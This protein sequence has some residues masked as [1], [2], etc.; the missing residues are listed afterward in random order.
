M[1][2][3]TNEYKNKIETFFSSKYILPKKIV[4]ACYCILTIT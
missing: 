1:N 3:L 2:Y 4:N